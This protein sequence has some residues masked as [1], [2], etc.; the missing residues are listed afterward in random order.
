MDIEKMIIKLEKN[1]YVVRYK[2]I[3][4][5]DFEK[6]IIFLIEALIKPLILIINRSELTDKIEEIINKYNIKNVIFEDIK[7]DTFNN[8]DKFYLNY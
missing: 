1:N 3:S 4:G 2:N 8:Y 6:N 5:Y 7:K